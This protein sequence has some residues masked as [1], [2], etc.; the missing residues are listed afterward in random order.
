[1]D[2]IIMTLEAQLIALK[3][4]PYTEEGRNAYNLIVAAIKRL[5]AE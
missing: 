1:M 2:A 5:K 4:Q 3:N